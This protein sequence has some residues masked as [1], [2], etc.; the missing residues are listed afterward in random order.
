MQRKAQLFTSESFLQNQLHL[1]VNRAAE[2]FEVPFHAHDFIEYCY[3]AEGR[4]FHHIEYDTFS[5]QKGMLFVIPVG[6]SH[7]FRPATADAHGNRLIVYNCL[8]DSHMVE[9]LSVIVQ[10]PHIREHLGSLEFRNS[11]YFSVFDHE[12]RI[13][14]LMLSLYREDTGYGEGSATMLTALLSELIVT[15]YR[16][17]FAAAGQYS[18]EPSDFTAINHY[19]K[20]NLSGTVTLAGLSEISKWSVRHLQRMFHRHTGQ[21]FGS[22]L[23]NLRVQKSCEL[24]RTSGQKITLIAESVGY[25]DMDSFTTVFKKIVGVSPRQYRKTVHSKSSYK[26][27]AVDSADLSD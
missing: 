24:L 8:F 19:L 25:R 3:V 20:Q 10:E 17:K 16:S 14:G 21:P 18:G 1:V 22:Y 26:E 9:R 5:V 2:D 7:V 12:G 4:G 27:R 23:Q 11:P 15:V 6:V 13:E